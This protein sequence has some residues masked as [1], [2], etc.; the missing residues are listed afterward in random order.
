MPNLKVNQMVGSVYEDMSTFAPDAVEYVLFTFCL[1]D[2][3]TYLK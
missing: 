3:K 1:E 2:P